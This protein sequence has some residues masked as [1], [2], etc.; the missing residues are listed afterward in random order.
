MDGA[1]VLGAVLLPNRGDAGSC[2]FGGSLE[3]ACVPNIA[4][5]WPK[6]TAPAPV[7]TN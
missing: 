1:V 7:A 2:G 3:G 5:G 4:G 6:D